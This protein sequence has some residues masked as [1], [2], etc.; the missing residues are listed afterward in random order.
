MK[1]TRHSVLMVVAPPLEG[2]TL[3]DVVPC[4]GC[5]VVGPGLPLV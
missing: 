4:G 3:V 1:G 5:A 2:D